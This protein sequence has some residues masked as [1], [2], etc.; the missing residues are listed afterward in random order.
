LASFLDEDQ[1]AADARAVFAND[2]A[3]EPAGTGRCLRGRAC[4]A[5]HKAERYRNNT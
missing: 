1:D 5:R 4:S 2:Y 3:L